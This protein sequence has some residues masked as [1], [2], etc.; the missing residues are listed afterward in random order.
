MVVASLF[1]NIR[2]FLTYQYVSIFV[3]E[4]EELFKAP[5]TALHT[6]EN[7]ATQN[8]ENTT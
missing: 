1:D 7:K 6:S 5:E 8:I 2:Q 4:L 3:N